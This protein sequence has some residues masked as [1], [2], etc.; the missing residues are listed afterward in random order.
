MHQWSV[1]FTSSIYTKSFTTTEFPKSFIKNSFEF[2][3]KLSNITLDSNFQLMS[4]D[5]VS[6]FTNISMELAEESKKCWNH[7]LLRR[8]CPWRN[9]FGVRLMLN[10]TF[11]KFN[12]RTCKQIFG[13]S[14]GSPLSPIFANI[15]QDD[16]ETVAFKKLKFI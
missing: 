12:G 9:F 1:I 3:E 6:L 16:I 13:T 14:I 2:V 7:I 4:L 15:V 5:V 8:L 10:S 11:F